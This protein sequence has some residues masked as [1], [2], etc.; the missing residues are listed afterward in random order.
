MNADFASGYGRAPEAVA[1]NVTRCVATG[2]A[3]LSIEDATGDPESPLYDLP[4]A[5]ERIRAALR[6]SI[7]PEYGPG[8]TRLSAA[9]EC[10]SSGWTRTSNPPVNSRISAA[11]GGC[12]A[13]TV[14]M[15]AALAV[16]T[17]PP[18]GFESFALNILACA[19]EVRHPIVRNHSRRVVLRAVGQ[20]QVDEEDRIAPIES[21]ARP[22]SAMPSSCTTSVSPFVHKSRVSSLASE[23]AQR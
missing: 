10:G 13:L 15:R 7:S 4:L 20:R 9:N 6:Q 5:V 22:A 12:M 14:G 21:A 23:N 1:E 17:W 11:G 8:D 19:P 2:V 16:A 18:T 3:G